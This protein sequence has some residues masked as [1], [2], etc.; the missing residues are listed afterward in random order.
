MHP[1]VSQICGYTVT[2]IL[3]SVRVG[4]KKKKFQNL[5]VV[6]AVRSD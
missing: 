1:A 5:Q 3:N 4:T 6:Q 2:Q